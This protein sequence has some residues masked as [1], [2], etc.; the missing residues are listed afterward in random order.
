M[1]LVW[2]PLQH[3]YDPTTQQFNIK[4]VA[5]NVIAP[6]LAIV[7][8][9]HTGAASDKNLTKLLETIRT[10]SSLSDKARDAIPSVSD[11][12]CLVKNSNW[13]IQYW[14]SASTAEDSAS[15]KYGYVKKKNGELERDKNATL[16]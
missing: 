11:I 5:N 3:A 10:S 6:L 8:K 13:T 14:L 12:A 16:E 4:A 9:K 7:N 2:I 1:H 15:T